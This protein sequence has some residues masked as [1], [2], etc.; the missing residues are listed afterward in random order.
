MSDRENYLGN[1]NLK[2]SGVTLGWNAEQI[3]EYVKCANDPVYFI[4]NYIK[5]VSIDK[6]LINFDIWPFQE[7]MVKTIVDHRFV[8]CKMPRQVGKTTTVAAALL[9]YV[10]FTDN[11]KIA[12]LAN[13]EKQSR[14]ILSRI[15]LAFE[16]LPRWLQQGVV[17]WNKGNI[18]LENGSKILASSTSSTAIRGDSFNLIYLDEFAFVPNNIQEEFFASVYPTIS[19]GQTSKVLI[20]STPNGMNMFY[21]LWSDSE[22][23]RNRYERVSVHWSDVPGRTPKWREETISNTSERQ[24]SQEFECEFL[25]SSNT[26]IDGKV[27]QRLTYIAPIHSSSNV[28]IYQ[29]PQKN[30][31]YIITVDTSRGVDIDYSAFVVFDITTIPYNIV[32]K[33]RAN[34]ISPLVYPNVIVQV[35]NLYNEAYILVENNDIGQQVVD[36]LHHDLEYPHVLTT[37]TRGKAGQRISTGF[38][39][40]TRLTLGVKTTKQVKRI[41]CGNFKSLVENDK[42]IINDFHL[43]YEMARFIENKASYEAEE[44]EHDDLV[45]CCVLF[46]WLANQP[47][48]KDLSETDARQAL[49]EGTNSLMEDDSMPFGWQDDGEDVDGGGSE[50]QKADSFDDLDFGP[51]KY[52]F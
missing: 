32:C 18:E 27:L 35:G 16:H 5:I 41:G 43:L 39:G 42:L 51:H 13:K 52:M 47:Y 49:V 31:R 44:G 23:G 15:Q 11:Y 17:Q 3:Q 1:Q 30:H 38:G 45:M 7:E 48:F 8:I 36:I 20:T 2:R 12:I 22:Q 14:E 28:D 4:K 40:N 46:S 26:L 33:F 24:F 29:Q 37:Q 50:W 21:R 34:D 19:S 6:G 9:W 25:G 10:L